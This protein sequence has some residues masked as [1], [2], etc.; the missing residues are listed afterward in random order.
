[1][2]LLVL[3][4]VGL[5][6]GQNQ[7]C[8][9]CGWC[10]FLS[11]HSCTVG[12]LGLLVTVCS[13]ETAG[14]RSRILQAYSKLHKETDFHIYSV[15]PAVSK[16]M[17]CVRHSISVGKLLPTLVQILIHQSRRN[18]NCYLYKFLRLKCIVS[19]LQKSIFLHSQVCPIFVF[20]KL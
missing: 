17:L 8:H 14:F 7:M 1:M 5:C 13:L 2:A 18:V 16:V 20:L 19:H 12:L 11:V 15:P 6:V 3:R 9:L 10:L 4:R